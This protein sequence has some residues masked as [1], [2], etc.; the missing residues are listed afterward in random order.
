M[1]KYGLRKMEKD[2]KNGKAGLG[3]GERWVERWVGRWKK[4]GLNL[5]LDPCL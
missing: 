3:D 2:G 5:G 4:M 1:E